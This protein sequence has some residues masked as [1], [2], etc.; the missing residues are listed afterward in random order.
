MPDVARCR[1]MGHRGR[2]LLPED[3]WR[4][5]LGERAERRHTGQGERYLLTESVERSQEGDQLQ[6]A[7]CTQSL[8]QCARHLKGE[9][10][11]LCKELMI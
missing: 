9:G 1:L 5:L 8:L 4:Q 7:K 11:R 3:A 10:T 2:L 6:P